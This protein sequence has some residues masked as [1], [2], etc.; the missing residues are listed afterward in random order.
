MLIFLSNSLSALCLT[1]FHIQTLSDASAA[2]TF[3]NIETKGEIAHHEQFLLL[4]Q[5]FQLL[6]LNPS[7]IEDCHVFGKIKLRR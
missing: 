2:E 7:Y 3:E 6:I 1:L 4:S 5:C